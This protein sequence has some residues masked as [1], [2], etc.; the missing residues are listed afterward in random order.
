M[1]LNYLYLREQVSRFNADNVACDSSRRA[2]REMAD[3]YGVLIAHQFDD[4]EARIEPAIIDGVRDG[5]AACLVRLQRALECQT[6]QWL[7]PRNAA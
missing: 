1:D 4:D 3:A 2:H 6:M 7:P 5:D